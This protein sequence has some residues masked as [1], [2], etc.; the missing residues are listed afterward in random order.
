MELNCV[1]IEVRLNIQTWFNV[2]FQPDSEAFLG[3]TWIRNRYFR[4]QHWRWVLKCWRFI[5][6]FTIFR[7][8]CVLEWICLNL[9]NSLRINEWSRKLLHNVSLYVLRIANSSSNSS[10]SLLCNLLCMAV[11][12]VPNSKEI[13]VG[14]VCSL[15]N[16]F[17]RT[18]SFRW[19]KFRIEEHERTSEGGR[20]CAGVEIGEE[21]DGSN[22]WHCRRSSEFPNLKPLALRTKL[23]LSLRP[24]RR[25]RMCCWVDEKNLKLIYW[26]SFTKCSTKDLK[27]TNSCRVEILCKKMNRFMQI[28]F[29]CDAIKSHQYF[30]ARNGKRMDHFGNIK[31]KWRRLQCDIEEERKKNQTAGKMRKY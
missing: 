17:T 30:C 5:L 14:V 23:K 28:N 18:T 6:S 22:D 29:L 19:N 27:N 4:D 10:R 3:K 11:F 25:R 20:D 26:T 2:A 15:R 7:L 13:E 9:I 21:P 16:V 24:W 12:A 8:L 1:F 31:V